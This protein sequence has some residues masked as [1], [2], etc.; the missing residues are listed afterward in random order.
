MKKSII[1][2]TVILAAT[3]LKAQSIF[4]KWTELNEY[5]EVMSKTF[6]P[7][8]NDN[9]EPLKTMANDLKM[10]ADNLA[11]SKIPME[12]DSK[13]IKKAVAQLKTDSKALYNQV[14]SKASDEELKKSIYALHDVFHKIVGLCRNEDHH[15]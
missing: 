3:Q 1:L 2:F 9:L 10:K 5:H 4:D 15:E 8:E 14:E 13:D 6:H 12:F 11:K 7:A